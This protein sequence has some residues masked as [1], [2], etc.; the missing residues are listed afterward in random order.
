MT[1]FNSKITSKVAFFKNVGVG[2]I[3]TRLGFPGRL[4]AEGDK[5]PPYEKHQA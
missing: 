3:P 4:G 1:T 5:P 2:F